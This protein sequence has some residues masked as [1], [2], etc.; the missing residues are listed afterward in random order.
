MTN[1]L[2]PQFD[3]PKPIQ[4]LVVEDER[5]VAR[6][7]KACLENLGYAVPEIVSSGSKAVERAKIIHPDLVLMDIRLEGEI[8]GIQAAQRIWQ[9]LH[10]PVIYSTGHSD[11][12]TV[13]RAMATEPFGYVLKPIKEQDLYVALRTALKRYESLIHQLNRLKLVK[14]QESSNGLPLEEPYQLFFKINHSGAAPP[15]STRIEQLEEENHRLQGLANTDAL[16]QIANRRYFD[17]YLEREWKRMLRDRTPLSLILCD[18]D[19]FK[20]YN[21]TW[22]HQA[23]DGC[24]RQVAQAIQRA[25]KRPTALVARY[26]GEEFAIILPQ[27]TASEA[28][29]IAED[30]RLTVKAIAL[31]FNTSKYMGL[32]SSSVT[33]SLGIA[34]T[35]PSSNVSSHDLISAADTALYESKEQ[36]RDRSRL[37]TALS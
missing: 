29:Q 9:E 10:I 1:C 33:I 27:T 11:R 30:I 8:D 25:L 26:G 34:T 18:I 7:I 37:S 20:I 17:S 32:P 14:P 23:G 3:I 24:L 15:N 5:V 13:E 36:G 28:V 21:D 4:V 12:A 2:P 22:G 19:Y 35:I 31:P 16:T 6:D